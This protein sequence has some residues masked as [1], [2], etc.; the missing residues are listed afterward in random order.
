[1]ANY[2]EIKAVLG[3]ARPKAVIILDNEDIFSVAQLNETAADK[4]SAGDAV[5]FWVPGSPGDNI[6]ITKTSTGTTIHGNGVFSGVSVN[7]AFAVLTVKAFYEAREG[8]LFDSLPV[9]LNFQV[10]QVG[11]A[12]RCWQARRRGPRRGPC[13]GTAP[14]VCTA[15][16]G[17]R[18][19]RARVA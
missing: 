3:L 2:S 19:W 15:S 7:D 14:T 5:K 4:L 10:L 16:S 12:G 13:A 9:I 11:C 6:T 17:R 1:M 18:P 8:M